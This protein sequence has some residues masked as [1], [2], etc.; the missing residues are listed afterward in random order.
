ML[1]DKM[2]LTACVKGYPLVN[3]VTGSR[4]CFLGLPTHWYTAR[5]TKIENSNNLICETFLRYWKI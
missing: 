1:S 4:Q 2:V 3:L 5:S